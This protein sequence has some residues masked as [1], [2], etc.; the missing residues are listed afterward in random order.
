MISFLGNACNWY[1]YIRLRCYLAGI[2]S[3]RRMVKMML[4]AMCLLGV[5]TSAV[6]MITKPCSVLQHD[7]KISENYNTFLSRVPPYVSIFVPVKTDG[8][9]AKDSHQAMY[10]YHFST[11]SVFDD[12]CQEYG[13]V[14]LVS[15][16]AC[17]RNA[18]TRCLNEICNIDRWS[19]NAKLGLG[20]QLVLQKY[21]IHI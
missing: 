19:S 12:Q 18:T 7:E 11:E 9:L 6:N 20:G 10:T 13:L 15:E 2:S 17:Y 1:I 5:S 4:M 3:I 21:M 8:Y 16:M 14:K